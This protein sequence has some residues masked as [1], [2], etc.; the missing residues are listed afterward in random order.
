M[1]GDRTRHRRLASVVAAFVVLATLLEGCTPQ[2]GGAHAGPDSTRQSAPQTA[3]ATVGDITP[4][5]SLDATV[6]APTAFQ[7]TSPVAGRLRLSSNG[8]LSIADGEGV[9]HPIRLDSRYT[10]VTPLLAQGASVTA[11]QP[12]A[13]ATFGGLVLQ[14]TLKPADILRFLK[15]TES[16]RAVKTSAAVSTHAKGKLRTG[17]GAETMAPIWRT[18]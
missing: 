6:V 13:D 11:G 8:G 9:L 17:T 14:A 16:A 4:V 2:A 12:I 7:I 10:R 15:Q 5:L 18:A 3:V 1:T